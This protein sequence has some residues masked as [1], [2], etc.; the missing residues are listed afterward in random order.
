MTETVFIDTNIPIY[1]A[2]WAHPF[3]QPSLAF[4]QRIALGEMEGV[5]DSE[6]LQ[7]ILYRFAAIN[8]PQHGFAIFDDFIKGVPSILPVE[9]E[10]VM[11]AREILMK[12][13][14][15][16]PRDAI[17]AAVMKNNDIRVIYSYDTH[18]DMIK[19]VRRKEP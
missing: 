17:H 7:E 15:I 3:K 11:L 9:K 12:S 4:L 6:V 16:K 18:F 13:P 19:G 2:G 5:S 10:D 14:G 1:A 8:E